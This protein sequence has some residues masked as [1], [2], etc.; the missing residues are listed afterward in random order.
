M[1]VTP[2]AKHPIALRNS[3]EFRLMFAKNVGVR[4]ARSHSYDLGTRV[5]PGESEHNRLHYHAPPLYDS[6]RP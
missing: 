1:I 2:V 3:A 4:F 6:M 5:S